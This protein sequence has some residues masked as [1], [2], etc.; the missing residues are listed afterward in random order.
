MSA[1]VIIDLTDE[2]DEML[3]RLAAMFGMS[4]GEALE[5]GIQE[6]LAPVDDGGGDGGGG[7]PIPM[8][9]VA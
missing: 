7:E 2:Q 3:T 4:R 1:R 8:E 5:I 9:E 6:L